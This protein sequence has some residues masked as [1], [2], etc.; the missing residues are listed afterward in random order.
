MTDNV[1]VDRFRGKRTS[2]VTG[3]ADAAQ[4]NHLEHRLRPC[5]DHRWY[6]R[7][8][9][10]LS[11]SLSVSPACL[12]TASNLD[13]IMNEIIEITEINNEIIVQIT[14][15]YVLYVVNVQNCSLHT[16]GD[17]T[18]WIIQ[19]DHPEV[20]AYPVANPKSEVVFFSFRIIP[21]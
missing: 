19:H 21:G 17:F 18:F 1:T 11:L 6:R 12:L 5:T 8:S 10:S 3:A 2:D 4:W 15:A 13:E 9:L 14:T 7:L 16:M 20:R